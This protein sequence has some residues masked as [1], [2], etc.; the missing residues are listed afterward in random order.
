ML[1]WISGSAGRK[2]VRERLAFPLK[3]RKGR[4]VPATQYK[5]SAGPVFR[6]SL[7]KDTRDP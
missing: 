5:N 2:T 4:G 1:S 3:K 6:A 7:F